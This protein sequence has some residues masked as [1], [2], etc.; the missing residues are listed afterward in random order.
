METKTQFKP[1]LTDNASLMNLPILKHFNQ[2]ELKSSMDKMTGGAKGIFAVLKL[3][4]I[5]GLAWAA[6]TYVLPPVFKALGATLAAGATGIA[7]LF[8]ILAAPAIFK[9]LKVLARKIDKAA[10][11]RDPFLE[12]EKQRGK[13]LENQQTFRV[14]K[15]NISALKH[16]MEVEAKKSETEA[17][18]L[19]NKIVTLRTKVQTLKTDLDD[20]V[21][22][23]GAEAR[24]SDEF[25]D[26]NALLAKMLSDSNRITNQLAQCKDFVQK[27]GS[28]A[29][30][31]K[32]FGQKMVMAETAME[33]KLADYDATVEMLKKDYEFSQKSRAATDAAKSA[34]MFTKTWELEFAMDVVTSTIASDIAITAGNLRD[35][36]T[37]TSQYSLDNDELYT[38]LNILADNIKTGADVVPVAKQYSNPDYKLT[39]DD[40]MK[41]GGFGN[42]DLM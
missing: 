23:G 38:N 1:N 20:M 9:H 40:K 10:I 39:T 41:S 13:L 11:K 33:I 37:L 12:L 30:I 6:W 26:G 36:D 8:F 35:I 28:R 3:A 4:L 21:A 15:G 2:D 27:Y 32:K 29:A 34:M 22:K 31:M 16:D 42:L 5:G 17:T 25:V 14:S 19:Q 18:T 24:N 7:I